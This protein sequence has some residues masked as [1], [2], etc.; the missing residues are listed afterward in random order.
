[1][2]LQ[3]TKELKTR[4]DSPHLGTRPVYEPETPLEGGTGEG[5]G[6]GAMG[7]EGKGRRGKRGGMEGRGG[8]GRDKGRGKGVGDG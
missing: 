3:D 6:E 1:M 5:K 2:P 7:R 4:S 8:E